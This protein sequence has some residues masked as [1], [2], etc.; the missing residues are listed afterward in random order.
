MRILAIISVA[1]A[2]MCV[3]IAMAFH[4][5]HQ[6][7]LCWRAVVEDGDWPAAGDCRRL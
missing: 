7:N 1:L 2:L 3:A 6:E 4:R 5:A